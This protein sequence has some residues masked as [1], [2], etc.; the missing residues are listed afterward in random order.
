[1]DSSEK[2]FIW[3]DSLFGTYVGVPHRKKTVKN[4]TKI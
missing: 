1:M 4:A 3:C 2:D